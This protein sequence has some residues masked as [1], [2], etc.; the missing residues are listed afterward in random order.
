[1]AVLHIPHAST[2]I[3]P[4]E[5]EQ[6]TLTAD[7]L[8]AEL[9]VMT[10]WFTDELFVLPADL[11]ESVRF[12]VS[13]LV[14]DPERFVDDS[15]EPMAQRGMGVIYERTSNGQM[16]RL[17]PD[18]MTRQRMIDTYY[19]P[20]HKLL[21]DA[22][23]SEIERTNAALVIDCHS[24][25]STSLPHESDQ[26]LNRPDICIGTDDFH[27]P[28]ALIEVVQSF[29]AGQGWSTAVNRPFAGALV[30]MTSYR[31]D[32]RVQAIMIEVNRNLY[33]NEHSGQ[34]LSSFASTAGQLQ[35]LLRELV[36]V[37]AASEHGYR[38]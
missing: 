31:T 2:A 6:F 34:R 11:A 16:L 4:S 20:H 26:S 38:E 30:P 37:S 8:H 25:S 21:E 24:F 5:L 1:V 32:S 35:E 33:I 13:R 14:V 28:R 23:D 29:C 36:R 22:V 17:S 27:T 12:P 9:L 18:A 7:E 10:D 3:P 15:A 19:S